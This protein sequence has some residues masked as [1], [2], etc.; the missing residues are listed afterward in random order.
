MAAVAAVVGLVAGVLLGFS[1]GGPGSPAQAGV[2]PEASTRVTAAATPD[3][4]YTVVLASIAIEKGRDVADARA[5]QLRNQ[6]VQPVGVLES[7]RYSTLVAGY[8]VIYSGQFPDKR[9]ADGHLVEIKSQFPSMAGS[10]V[11]PVRP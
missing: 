1:S 10:Y 11:R 4:F 5:A 8:F 9:A 7:S 2:A 6:G 3:R